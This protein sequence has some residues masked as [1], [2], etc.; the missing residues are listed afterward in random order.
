MASISRTCSSLKTWTK[1][2]KTTYHLR[3]IELSKNKRQWLFCNNVT[4]KRPFR[5][6]SNIHQ[7]L[8]QRIVS[9]FPF[10]EKLVSMRQVLSACHSLSI[11][12]TFLSN[13]CSVFFEFHMIQRNTVHYPFDAYTRRILSLPRKMRVTSF[14]LTRHEKKTK[15]N[16]PNWKPSHRKF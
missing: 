7:L 1:N 10:Q 3:I 6:T 11:W 8:R 15:K 16:T 14:T 13:I 5:K 4:K 12:H 2:L 9:S